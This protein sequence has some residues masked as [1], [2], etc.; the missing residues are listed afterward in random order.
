MSRDHCKIWV[1]FK[2]L[3]NH[4][5]CS[6]TG[7]PILPC[8]GAG[9]PGGLCCIQ[10]MVGGVWSSPGGKGV[11]FLCPRVSLSQAYEAAWICARERGRTNLSSLI[12]SIQDGVGIQPNSQICA[13]PLCP[14]QPT[15]YPLITLFCTPPA[16]RPQV[17]RTRSGFPGQLHGVPEFV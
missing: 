3:A 15:F 6:E 7:S 5:F 1:T 8:I 4:V 14:C 12:G 17:G 9:R 13:A 11:F 16:R 10:H 2:M